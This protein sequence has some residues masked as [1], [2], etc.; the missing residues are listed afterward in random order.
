MCHEAPERVAV[1]RRTGPLAVVKTR[2]TAVAGPFISRPTSS[3]A[4]STA[5]RRHSRAGWTTAVD[6][7]FRQLAI[8]H[9]T[10]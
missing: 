2:I 3:A 1:T 8:P 5:T 6:Q 9:S 4:A 10:E 7:L